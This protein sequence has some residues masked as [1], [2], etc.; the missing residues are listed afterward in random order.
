MWNDDFHHALH[1][2][3]DRRAPRLLLRL[4]RLRGAGRGVLARLRLRGPLLAAPPAPPRPRRSRASRARSSSASRR[5]T[6]RSATAPRGDR[7]SA[8]ALPRA[9]P[10]RGGLVLYGALHPAAVPGRGVGR[11]ARRSPSSAT[12]ATRGLC[13]SVRHGRRQATG[14][15]GEA[16]DDAPDPCAPDTFLAAKLDWSELA[17]PGAPAHARVAP[18]AAAAAQARARARR[19]TPARRG[20]ALQREGGLDPAAARPG[21]D[22]RAA[23]ATSA[24][25][26]R[27]SVSHRSRS[28][29]PPA[30]TARSRSTASSSR[31]TASSRLAAAATLVRFL[32]ATE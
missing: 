15:C 8:T 21:P 6:T 28:S 3:A 22:R 1:A 13:D 17:A 20:R 32:L 16:H 18:V 9:P 19:G 31:R 29:S 24:S 4:R 5:T 27:S 12:T 11:A 25:R 14:T 26:F 23:S 30:T 10:G 7:L 2:F